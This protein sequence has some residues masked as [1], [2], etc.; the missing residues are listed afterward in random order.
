MITHYALSPF[1][2]FAKLQREMNRL[3]DIYGED[4]S[5][6]ETYPAVNVWGSS[7]EALITA[8]IPGIELNDL[9]I[10]VNNNILSIE[11]ERKKEEIGEEALFHRHERG[12]GK[13]LKTI[14]LPFEV[15]NDKINATY[16]NGILRIALPRLESS[17]PRRI[18][19]VKE[20][21]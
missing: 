16:S 3:F 17:K 20:N 6:Y 21:T 12:F 14:R 9:H 18:E 8:E 19:I 13:F 15:E 1:T 11:G 7:N 5:E 10:T 4:Y 2:D